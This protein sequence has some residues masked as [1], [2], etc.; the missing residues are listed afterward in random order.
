MRFQHHFFRLRT[1]NERR[2][3]RGNSET[4]SKVLENTFQMEPPKKFQ[5]EKVKKIIEEVLNT[6]LE[7]Q[8]YDA[9]QCSTKARAL[10]QQI[11]AMVKELDFKRYK[12]IALVSIGEKKDQ[13][14]RAGSRCIWD[15]NRDTYA[16]A[17]YENRQIWAVG[18]VYG[19]YY[20]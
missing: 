20:E 12:I 16:S 13:D 4:T 1:Q 8:A 15:V 19:I 17:S 7:G 5:A 18:T 9:S 10:S 11:K 6:H 14:V 3:P 2:V